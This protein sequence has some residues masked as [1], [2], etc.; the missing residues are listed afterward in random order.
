MNALP[1]FGDVLK[2]WP[3]EYLLTARQRGRAKVVGAR[4]G[5]R[6]DGFIEVSIVA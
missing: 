6:V 3:N 1:Q 4:N 5:I 2:K